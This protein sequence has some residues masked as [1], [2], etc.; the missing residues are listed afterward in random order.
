MIYVVFALCVATSLACAALLA[1][2]WVQTRVR[3]L[4]ACSA[5][6]LGMGISHALRFFER[7]NSME[8]ETFSTIVQV[9]TLLGVTILLWGLV[10]AND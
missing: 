6:F 3:L 10:R 9:P 2:G 1:R 5:C 4:L 7:W 8:S